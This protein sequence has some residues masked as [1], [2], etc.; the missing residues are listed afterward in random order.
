MQQF[1]FHVGRKMSALFGFISIQ[2]IVFIMSTVPVIGS[3][4]VL[5]NGDIKLVCAGS[6]GVA[7]A[8]SFLITIDSISGSID[9]TERSILDNPCSTTPV[10]CHPFDTTTISSGIWGSGGNTTGE[11]LWTASVPAS[12]NLASSYH[13]GFDIAKIGRA[14]WRERG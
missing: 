5:V 1:H 2:V 8:D 6:S 14:S 7:S 12:V 3:N 13:V 10:S 4:Q 11:F 9:D